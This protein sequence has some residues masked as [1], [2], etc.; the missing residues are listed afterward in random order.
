MAEG[1][2]S[3][4]SRGEG[5]DSQEPTH[6]GAEAAGTTAPGG[7]LVTDEEFGGPGEDDPKTGA[8]ADGLSGELP[9]DLRS[10]AQRDPAEE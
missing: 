2:P 9:A 6:P 7:G 3:T 1:L 4:T 8:A 5:A 10:T